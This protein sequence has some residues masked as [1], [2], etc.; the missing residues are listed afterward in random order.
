MARA[1]R[2]VLH[3]R[4]GDRADALADAGGALDRDRSALTCYQAASAYLLVARTEDDRRKGLDLLREAIRNDRNG[5]WV[6]HMPTDPDLKAV[7]ESQEF[8]DLMTAAGV[9]HPAAKTARP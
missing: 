1:G 8:K 6:K 9:L 2:A 3:A 5:E 7:R 4:L